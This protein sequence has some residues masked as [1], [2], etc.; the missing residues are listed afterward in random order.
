M[1]G[2]IILRF[3]FPFFLFAQ[4]VVMDRG[5]VLQNVTRGARRRRRFSCWKCATQLLIAVDAPSTMELV[6][7]QRPQLTLTSVRM[8]DKLSQ[9]LYTVQVYIPI[10]PP[11]SATG[12]F[13]CSSSRYTFVRYVCLWQII[14]KRLEI[15]RD[16]ETVR[17]TLLE[18]YIYIYI[19][20]RFQLNF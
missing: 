15:P 5:N 11:A 14:S 17:I 4:S 10:K 7:I 6:A 20:P 2:Y 18:F 9:S 1:E 19:C 3:F 8:Y 13:L 12:H 16:S